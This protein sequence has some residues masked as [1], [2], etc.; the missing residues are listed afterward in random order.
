MSPRRRGLGG[1]RP[2][3]PALPR[4]IR[5]TGGSR[6][7]NVA[8]GFPSGNGCWP[9][10]CSEDLHVVVHCGKYQ[11]ARCTDG[12][13]A[14]S[15]WFDWAG[16]YSEGLAVVRRGGKEYHYRPDGTPAYSERFDRA[17]PFYRGQAQ[18]VRSSETFYIYPDGTRAR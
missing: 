13:P 8:A 18:V 10:T 15:Q 6:L 3:L 2:G 11:H 1:Y 12:Q 4:R 9:F 16:P 5:H 14:Y 7:E 17:R